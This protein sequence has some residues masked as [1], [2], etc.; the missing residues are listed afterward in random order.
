M[1]FFVNDLLTSKKAVLHANPRNKFK[2]FA[3][4]SQ[5]AKPQQNV[6]LSWDHITLFSLLNEI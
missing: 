6:R 5:H 1:Q 2:E 3:K 4:K